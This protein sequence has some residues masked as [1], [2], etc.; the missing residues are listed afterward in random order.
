MVDLLP[1]LK[2]L[3]KPASLTMMSSSV[4]LRRSSTNVAAAAPEALG[5]TEAVVVTV[6]AV[7][8]PAVTEAVVTEAAVTEAAVPVTEAAP[9]AVMLRRH[10]TNVAAVAPEAPGV[11]EAVVVMVAVVVDPAVTEAVVTEA[12]V[13]EAAVPVTEAAP[14]AVMLRRNSTNVAAVAPEAPGVTEAVVVTVAAVVDPAVTEA[15]VM[16]AAVTEAAAPVTEAAPSAVSSP[17][18]SRSTRP[19]ALTRW[20][21]LSESTM[22]SLTKAFEIL[23]RL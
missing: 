2:P 10:S 4:S 3:T 12:A 9:S 20:R 5:V 17:R 1:L 6:A 19:V 14:S 22:T 16:E 8:D 13:T 11:T 15:V 7:V 21:P 23:P 18:S